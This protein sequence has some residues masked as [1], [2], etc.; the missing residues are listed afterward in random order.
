MDLQ[1]LAELHYITPIINV[2]S[3]CAH[4]ILSHNNAQRVQHDSVALQDVQNKRSQK[5]VPFADG[6]F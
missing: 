6:S 2:P 1:D 3:I 4:G 5:R